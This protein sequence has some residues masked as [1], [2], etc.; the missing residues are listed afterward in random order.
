MNPDTLIVPDLHQPFTRDDFL[1]FCLDTARKYKT[2]RTV[3]IGD[4]VDQHALSYHEHSPDGYVSG[5]VRWITKHNPR[6]FA[7]LVQQY[8]AH[9]ALSWFMNDRESIIDD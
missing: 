3:F 8:T 5:V 1:D 6:F 7:D 2:K 9:E 4:L